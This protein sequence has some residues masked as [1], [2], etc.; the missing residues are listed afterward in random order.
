MSKNFYNYTTFFY[1]ELSNHKD[2]F[3]NC[4]CALGDFINDMNKKQLIF[5]KDLYFFSETF[6]YLNIKKV[7]FQNEIK[8]IIYIP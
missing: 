2:C 3:F 5:Y 8:D 4:F 7:R 1:I 6:I